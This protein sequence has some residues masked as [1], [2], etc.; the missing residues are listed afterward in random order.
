MSAWIQD[1]TDLTEKELVSEDKLRTLQSEYGPTVPTKSVSGP[2]P[3]RE[4]LR[5]ID[6]NAKWDEIKA[7]AKDV[8]LRGDEEEI[9]EAIESHRGI[10]QIWKQA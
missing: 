4:L 3:I 7:K 10:P 6:I 8:G 9:R 2:M 1:Q 5:K